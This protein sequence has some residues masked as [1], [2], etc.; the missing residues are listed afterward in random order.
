VAALVGQ[1][2]SGREALYPNRGKPDPGAAASWPSA[3]EWSGRLSF[4]T[5]LL[6]NSRVVDNHCY[7]ER[8]NDVL[9]NSRIS[10]SIVGLPAY[11]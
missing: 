3:P 7:P 5:M 8:Q 9:G 1:V 10:A 11:R 2:Q 4:L 6:D